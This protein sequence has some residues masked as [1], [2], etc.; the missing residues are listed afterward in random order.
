VVTNINIPSS[1]TQIGKNP[2]ASRGEK[3]KNKMIKWE[4]ER[5]EMPE[6]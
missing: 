2:K 1:C 3:E 5:A 6:Y 4:D